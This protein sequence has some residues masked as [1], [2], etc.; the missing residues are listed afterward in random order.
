MSTRSSRDWLKTRVRSANSTRRRRLLF[1]GVRDFLLEDRCLLSTSA[2]SIASKFSVA[3]GQTQVIDVS[4]TPVIVLKG[5]LNDQGTVYLV[6][7]N[8]LEQRV[9]IRAK[10]IIEGAGAIFTTVL[11]A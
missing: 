1:V 6:S 9:T 10:N 5:N 3:R 11:P 8:P 7:T 2:S 4:N